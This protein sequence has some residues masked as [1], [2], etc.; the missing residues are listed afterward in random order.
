MN[1]KNIQVFRTNQD[2][3]FRIFING[4]K[5]DSCIYPSYTYDQE[6]K[7]FNT[8]LDSI[9]AMILE[10]DIPELIERNLIFSS[11]LKR[12]RDLI[13]KTSIEDWSRQ[14]NE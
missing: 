13:S 14:H 10:T 4:F 6:I 3:G 7:H 9:D 11:G 8:F 12:Y 1:L 5:F 2:I